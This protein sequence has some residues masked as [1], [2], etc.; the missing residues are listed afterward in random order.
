M[1]R[2]ATKR[3]TDRD[4]TRTEKLKSRLRKSRASVPENV[5]CRQTCREATKHTTDR[6]QTQSRLP[7]SRAYELEN[8]SV[9]NVQGGH[10]QPNTLLTETKQSNTY[11]CRLGLPRCQWPYHPCHRSHRPRPSRPHRPRSKGVRSSSSARGM[12]SRCTRLSIGKV[13]DIWSAEKRGIP[14]L[15]DRSLHPR[16]D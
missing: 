6:N 1:C 15:S 12:R 11:A 4:Q 7:D 10:H 9:A 5:L 3:T 16:Y 8:A 13:W 2:E 14:G